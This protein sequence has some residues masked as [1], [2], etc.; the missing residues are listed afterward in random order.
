MTAQLLLD[1]LARRAPE[2]ALLVAPVDPFVEGDVG[3]LLARVL[4]C[5]ER[6]VR[7]EVDRGVEQNEPRDE[8][9]RAR[10]ELEREPASERVAD[11]H[12]GR[13]RRT[14]STIASM[15]V[16]EVPG[17]LVRGGAVPEQVRRED[18]EAG[19]RSRRASRSAARGS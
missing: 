12:R 13:G 15:C 8:L 19:Q 18:V 4:G 17:R 1:E 3:A 10:R 9:R 11:E 7:E 2:L 14:V 5:E 16:L 6:D